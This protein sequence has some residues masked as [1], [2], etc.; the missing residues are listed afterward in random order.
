M[1]VFK[2]IEP[3]F[4][5]DQTFEKQPIK[6]QTPTHNTNRL[7]HYNGNGLGLKGETLFLLKICI[8]FGVP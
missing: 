5:F 8:Y 4:K 2:F 1:F 3:D 7:V 6:A